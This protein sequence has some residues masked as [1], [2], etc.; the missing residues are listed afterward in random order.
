MGRAKDPMLDLLRAIEKATK[1]NTAELR[2]QAKDE[3]AAGRDFKEH[4]K[5]LFSRAQSY[6]Q[7]GMSGIGHRM[8]G[9]GGMA[10]GAKGLGFAGAAGAMSKAAGPAGFAIAGMDAAASGARIMNDPFATGDQKARSFA[11]MAPG[12]ET[13]MNW[14]DSFSGRAAGMEMNKFDAQKRSAGVSAALEHSA[15]AM[16]YNPQ[17]AGYSA[18]A[19]AYRGGS[20]V[21]GG[22]H[23]RST[24][25][26]RTAAEDAQKMLPYRQATAKAEREMAT[27]TA[28]RV[29][30]QKDLNG[31]E[32][33]E[34][35]VIQDI[36]KM[37]KQ[38]D[39]EGG[40][41]VDRDA[42]VKLLNAKIQE[43]EGINAQVKQAAQSLRS[44]RGQEA[45]A[46]GEYS[47]AQSREK[48][49]GQA[50]ILG[51]RAAEAQQTARSLGGMNPMER[52]QAFDVMKMIKDGADPDMVPP[53]LKALAQQ[54]FPAE[55][56]AA[57]EEKGRSS[58]V[59]G[60]ATAAGFRG[61]GDYVA[62]GKQ[63]DTLRE[64]AGK[65]EYA[66]DTKIAAT[67]ERSGQ[68]LGNATVAAMQRGLGIAIAKI[69]NAFIEGRGE[70]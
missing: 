53:Q 67:M 58:G 64:Q 32:K 8:A 22:V 20:A 42:K 52:Q 63:A 7:S 46:G 24:T 48:L 9:I 68:E 19:A 1:E 30:S 29:A 65:E 16:S 3:K 41:G 6:S 56:S 21:T 17:Q 47:K 26:G 5:E 69:K 49:L 31:L 60:Q 23:D 2:K 37:S 4:Q 28:Q 43:G 14:A 54:A 18:T 51:G 38:L 34:Y 66:A 50:D 61:A 11:K 27:A 44:A 35:R 57:I 10:S 39:D 25:A 70:Q 59:M 13:V 33:A 15:F 45:Q 55:F 62:L 40:S 36:A 12:G